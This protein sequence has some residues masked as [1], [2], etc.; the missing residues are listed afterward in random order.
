MFFCQICTLPLRLIVIEFSKVLDFNNP[1]VWGSTPHP[2]TV[3]AVARRAK[4]AELAVKAHETLFY[5]L[6]CT[7]LR[8]FSI[9]IERIFWII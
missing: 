9:C 4:E 5:R 7:L 2:A 1:E 3:V 6:F 8:N